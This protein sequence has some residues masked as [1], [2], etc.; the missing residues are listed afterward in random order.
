MKCAIAITTAC[1]GARGSVTDWEIE[2]ANA[3]VTVDP[4]GTVHVVW[5]DLRAAYEEIYHSLRGE[6]VWT[7]TYRLSTPRF[8]L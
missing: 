2:A 5:R 4:G 7:P 3:S 8:Q 6:G 1:P